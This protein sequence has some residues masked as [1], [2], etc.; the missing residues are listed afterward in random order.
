MIDG[1]V[2]RWGDGESEYYGVWIE[3]KSKKMLRSTRTEL[4][5]DRAA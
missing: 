1:E 4:M 2:G 5:L 3:L